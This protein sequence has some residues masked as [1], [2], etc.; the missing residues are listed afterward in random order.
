MFSWNVGFCN[1]FSF[2]LKDWIICQK[3]SDCFLPSLQF[4]LFLFCLLALLQ[5]FLLKHDNLFIS[6]VFFTSFHFLDQ[7]GTLLFLFPIF[8]TSLYLI[9]EVLVFSL[10]CVWFLVDFCFGLVF[11]FLF[12]LHYLSLLSS[13][14]GLLILF[15]ISSTFP[16]HLTVLMFYVMILEILLQLQQ[17]CDS[18]S[19]LRYL[20]SCTWWEKG[21][22]QAE[23]IS[24]V[25]SYRVIVLLVCSRTQGIAQNYTSYFSLYGCNNLWLN[26]YRTLLGNL[27]HWVSID[28]KTCLESNSNG[29]CVLLC[30]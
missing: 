16:F 24:Y 6:V 3:Y 23:K 13:S 15:W 18:A 29:C 7:L 25:C 14:P 2:P 1:R 19:T 8:L 26:I 28:W 17:F 11:F 30:A 4:L 20:S 21:C 10:L 12:C 5:L 9:I 27:F 22:L